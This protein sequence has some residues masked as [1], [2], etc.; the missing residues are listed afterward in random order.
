MKISTVVLLAIVTVAA[1]TFAPS[2]ECRHACR[3]DADGVA[4]AAVGQPI[5]S[6]GKLPAVSLNSSLL[7][8]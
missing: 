1:A 4:V 6:F 5:A 2:R 3:M 8:N 7:L